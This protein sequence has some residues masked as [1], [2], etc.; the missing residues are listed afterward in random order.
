[1]AGRPAAPGGAREPGGSSLRLA[2]RSAA[3]A[4]TAPIARYIARDSPQ[5]AS[6]FIDSPGESVKALLQRPQIGKAHQSTHPELAGL[7][8]WPVQHF[9]NFRIHYRS[10]EDEIVIIRVLHG[11]RDLR[12]LL[13]VPR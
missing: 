4:D 11:A 8:S 7:R 5:A 12:E 3:E 1:M 2:V 6:R 10:T 9:P 13:G